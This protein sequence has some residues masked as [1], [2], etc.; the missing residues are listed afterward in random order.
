MGFV[1]IGIF[2][3]T[4]QGVAGSIIQM[5]SHGVVSG[6]LFLCV[7]VVYDRLHSREIARYG[8]LVHNMP[9]YAFFFMV[10]ILAGVGLPGTSGFVGEFLTL[11]GAY[12]ANTWVAMLA[13]T[14][15][16][17]GA[18]YSLWLYRRAIF[19][20]LEKE[21]LKR[22]LDCNRREVLIF[23]PLVV[24][25]FWMGIYPT[26]FLDVVAVS[27]D[28]LLAQHEAALAAAR[29]LDGAGALAAELS[30]R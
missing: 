29:A 9:R 4:N 12:Q 5:L 1:T 21:D 15:I 2:T 20:E 25:V 14:G 28:N 8:G 19:G 18:A 24:V 30:A 3:F 22:M 13:T 10:F 6:A 26:P 11:V 7:G 23:V 27:V 16:I 17:L